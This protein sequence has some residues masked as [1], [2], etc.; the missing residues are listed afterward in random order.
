MTNIYSWHRHEGN[1]RGI[2]R[3]NW[4]GVE[5]GGALAYE[6]EEGARDKLNPPSLQSASGMRYQ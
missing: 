6:V 1:D 2:C 3:R 5:G 4:L